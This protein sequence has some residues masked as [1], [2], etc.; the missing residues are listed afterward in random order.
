MPGVSFGPFY[1]FSQFRRT[2]LV[3]TLAWA[4]AREKQVWGQGEGTMGCAF[5]GS[6]RCWA[7]IAGTE[8]RCRSQALFCPFWYCVCNRTSLEGPAATHPSTVGAT[9]QQKVRLG[10]TWKPPAL[11][12]LCQPARH[13][14]ANTGS[15]GMWVNDA[16]SSPRLGIPGPIHQ[17]FHV[18]GFALSMKSC[19]KMQS[20]T[21]L[22]CWGSRLLQS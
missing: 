10:G 9:E 12:S 22:P 7:W 15:L 4:S 21:L 20:H 14:R 19:C 8:G 2:L 18:L 1:L 11:P 13:Q 17:R 16:A 3:K 5:K 6:D